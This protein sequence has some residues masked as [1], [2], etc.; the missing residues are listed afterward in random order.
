MPL[1]PV[2][3]MQYTFFLRVVVVLVAGGGGTRSYPLT[4][5]FDATPT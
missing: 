4:L 1:H 3:K 5:M 2:S